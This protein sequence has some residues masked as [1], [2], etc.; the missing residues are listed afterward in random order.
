[1]TTANGNVNGLSQIWGNAPRSTGFN[2]L[3]MGDGFKAGTQQQTFDHACQSFR[4]TLLAAAPFNQLAAKINI[5]KLNVAS[6]ESGA[7]D[8]GHLVT[9]RTYFDSTFDSGSNRLLICNEPLAQ[10]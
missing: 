5:F 8:M 7:G 1:M 6:L 9:R 3:L 10:T 4:Q 2:I